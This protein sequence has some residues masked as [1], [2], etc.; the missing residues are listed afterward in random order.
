MNPNIFENIEFFL[1]LPVALLALNLTKYLGRS[2][3]VVAMSGISLIFIAS[4]PGIK[5]VYLVTT[6]A[7]L[8]IVYLLLYVSISRTHL[9]QTCFW[10]AI[11]IWLSYFIGV[12]YQFW[13]YFSPVILDIRTL[14]NESLMPIVGLSF[15]IVKIISVIVDIRAERL[16]NLPFLDY[17]A[18]I[19]W[20]PTFMSGPI[21]RLG[22]FRVSIDNAAANRQ[23]ILQAYF[24]NLPRFLLGCLKVFVVAGVLHKD[25]L[26]F[27]NGG[28]IPAAAMQV[29]FA[30][31][32]YYWYEYMNF[33]GYSDI[34][35][36]SS[37][38]IGINLP[39]NFDHPYMAT[40]LTNLWR[41]WHM[42]L[43]AW[44]RDYIYYP[45]FFILM[46]K[47]GA[48]TKAAQTY[49]SALSIFITF[50]ICG[51]WH[52]ETY[53]ML[54]FGISSGLVLAVEVLLSSNFDKPLGAYLKA[55][56][57]QAQC[58]PWVARLVT[59]HIAIITFGPVLLSNEQ[60]FVL[61]GLD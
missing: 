14:L 36:S 6:S 12:K 40:S 50:A 59:F 29:Y 22:N 61:F 34:A 16:K 39:E 24:D 46:K 35:I 31:I 54:F 52:G 21:E 56:P 26:P 20:F 1:L 19:L 48:K 41:R 30:A 28:I 2:I 17:L 4:I 32:I 8:V 18:Y 47:F 49:L 11:S 33:S 23:N 53:G 9:K 25:A 55:H 27:A 5:Y 38:V 51:L 42:T 60:F 44:L 15:L 43:A 57:L 13:G 10:V 3:F 58:Y 37:R 45:L 7:I